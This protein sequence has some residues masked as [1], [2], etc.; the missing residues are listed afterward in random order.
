MARVEA[1]A[2]ARFAPPQRSRLA[3]W[4]LFDSPVFRLGLPLVTAASVIL[5]VLLGVWALSLNGEVA[6]LRQQ[7]ALLQQQLDA[8]QQVI[9]LLAEPAMQAMSIAG[10]DV[11]PEA[12]GKMLADPSQTEALLVVYDLEPLPPDR[13]YQFWL[14]RGD[15][16]V[17]AGTFT[18][19]DQGRAILPVASTE[20]V[21]SFDA[22]GVSI[23][24]AGGSSQP[25]GDI[26]MLGTLAPTS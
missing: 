8:Q 13:V 9:A 23:E 2:R 6:R 17:S 5:I 22:I 25:T 24:P 15:T 16:P 7:T 1:D 3:G 19:D 14:I 4:R 26:V 11:Q 12:R 18:V 10:T 20:A 21:G